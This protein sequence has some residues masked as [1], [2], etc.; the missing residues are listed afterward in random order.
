MKA[1]LICISIFLFGMYGLAGTDPSHGES[2]KTYKLI[3]KA[4][5]VHLI[6]SVFDLE[7]VGPK[8]IELLNYY[9]SILKTNNC[10]TVRISL[11]DLKD[12]SFYPQKDERAL[13]PPAKLEDI[14]A[15]QNLIVE[16]GY[17]SFYHSPIVGVVTSHYG[18]REGKLHKG[19]DI[20]LNKGDKVKAAFS[21]KV[22]IARRQGGFGNVVVVMH[23]NGLETVYA[24]LSRIKVK[25]GDV[26]QSGQTVGLGGNTGHS[27]GSHLHF[28]VR[29]KGHP[30]NPGAII[31][32]TENKMIH[33][34][35]IIKNTKQGLCAFPSNSNLHNVSKGESWLAI[36]G[37]YG[38]SLKE[39]MALNGV[40]RRY[41]LKAGQQLRIN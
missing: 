31:S 2:K 13:F 26:V 25:P 10:D 38:L 5:L 39:L 7:E 41:Y 20:D 34:S 40:A 33:H 8:D 35:I 24:H 29:Y 23:P 32:F 15:T 12:L 30:L 17:L 3:T 21:G 18:W 22:R 19:I 27:S 36:A 4:R 11:L 28:E 16:N 37:K 14:P 6:D 1:F 9:A